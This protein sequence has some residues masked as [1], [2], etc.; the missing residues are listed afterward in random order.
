[1]MTKSEFLLILE[2]E[3]ASLNSE[4]RNKTI[5][6]Y[7]EL[8]SDMIENGFTQEEAVQKLGK[9]ELIAKEIVDAQRGNQQSKVKEE[10]KKETPVQQELK[11]K[12]RIKAWPFVL[13]GVLLVVTIIVIQVV[14]S[15]IFNKSPR[16]KVVLEYN[17]STI[18]RNAYWHD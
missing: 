15:I 7:S 16:E 11:Q 4:E 3:L 6:Y 2:K 12:K 10:P 5:T 13:G 1:M 8:I 14:G 17:I 18:I 9:P